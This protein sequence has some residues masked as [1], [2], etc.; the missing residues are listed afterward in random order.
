MN[1]TKITIKNSLKQE[2]KDQVLGSFFFEK[3]G[4][5]LSEKYY[6][7][8]LINDLLLKQ[9]KKSIMKFPRL[10]KL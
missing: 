3:R 1:S 9:I 8:V 6:K 5:A 4:E 10:E 2:K 7:N